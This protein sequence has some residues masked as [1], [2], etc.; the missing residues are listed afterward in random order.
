MNLFHNAVH[1]KCCFELLGYRFSRFWI[2]YLSDSQNNPCISYTW[3]RFSTQIT[4]S[5]ATNI[6]RWWTEVSATIGGWNLWNP[7]EM[8]HQH[9]NLWCRGTLKCRC[10]CLSALALLSVRPKLK[11]I[12]VWTV[13]QSLPWWNNVHWKLSIVQE[14]RIL[15]RY[16]HYKH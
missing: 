8:L 4:C 12:W 2:S 5:S 15:A 9:T 13:V 16:V 14:N 6:T 1:S 3:L 7:T 10:R 11:L